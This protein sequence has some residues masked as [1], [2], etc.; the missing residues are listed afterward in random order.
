MRKV[1]LHLSSG[2]KKQKVARKKEKEL[3]KNGEEEDEGVLAKKKTISGHQDNQKNREVLAKKKPRN[4]HQDSEESK[5]VL[6]KKK[7]LVMTFAARKRWKLAK[8]MFI[9][10]RRSRVG[11]MA[12]IYFRDYIEGGGFA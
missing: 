10:L 8:N 9:A 6:V 3:P 5:E 2:A 1:F 7:S 11:A 12:G 4:G